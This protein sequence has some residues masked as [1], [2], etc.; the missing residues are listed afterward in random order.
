MGKTPRI[1]ADRRAL[2]CRSVRWVTEF[3][4]QPRCRTLTLTAHAARAATALL[5]L[6]SL[7]VA[8]PRATPPGP[9]S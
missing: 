9:H 6:I 5:L 8:P 1:G 7:A 4:Q 2:Q 3:P